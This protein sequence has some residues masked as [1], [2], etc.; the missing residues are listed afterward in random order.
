MKVRT[1]ACRAASGTR[2]RVVA[3]LVEPVFAEKSLVRERLQIR[4]GRTRG[5]DERERGRIRGDHEVV[6]EAALEP[7]TRHAE[8]AVL[9]VLV[10]GGEVVARLGDAP[11]HAALA[12]VFDLARDRRL[13]GLIEER[14][15]VTRH[16][17]L[18]H[19]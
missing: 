9:I 6:R 4:A 3:G 7:E 1:T 19:E 18:R 15:L 11:G 14:V 16:Q 8:G 13:E 2:W 17:Q 10:Q 12:A 5:D